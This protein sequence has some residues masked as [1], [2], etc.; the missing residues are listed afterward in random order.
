MMRRSLVTATLLTALGLP[1]CTGGGAFPAAAQRIDGLRSPVRSLGGSTSTACRTQTCIYVTNNDG[2]GNYSQGNKVLVFSREANG[3]AAPIAQIRGKKTGLKYPRAIALDRDRSVYVSNFTPGENGSSI[4]VYPAGATGNA[5]PARKITGPNTELYAPSS[6]S[7][8]ADGA[9]YVTDVYG[10]AS[11]CSNPT[12]GCWDVNVYAAGANGD[13]APVQSIRGQQTKLYYV[14]GSAVDA[15][16]NVYVAN[17]YHANCCVTVYAANSNGDVKPL[18]NISGSKTGL[19]TP[20]GLALDARGD[21]FVLNA[22]GSPTRSVTVY[23][24]GAH[25]N[26]KPIRT[27]SGQNTGLYA[28]PVAIAVDGS[29]RVYVV[30]SGYANSISVFATGANGDVAP[31]RVIQGKNTGMTSPWGIAVR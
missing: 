13:A 4:T 7:V 23:A 18:R 22:E 10:A 19:A 27:I 30:Q 3:N 25:G 29:G 17:G 1:A 20:V 2:Y 12:Q 21:V 9:T 26:V 11:G 14:Y 6:V 31:V 28:A 5:P 24:P 8:A 16:G 15:S